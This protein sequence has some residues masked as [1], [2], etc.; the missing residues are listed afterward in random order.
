MF[1][2]FD[3]V[4]II[5]LRERT[6]RRRTMRRELA[7]VGGSA[8]FYDAIRPGSKGPFASAGLYGSFLSHQA[9]IRD[10]AWS[11]ESVLIIEDDCN[12]LPCAK[13]YSVPPCDVFYGSHSEDADEIVGAHC[14]GFS[15]RAVVLLDRYLSDFLH[16]DFEGEGKRIR[17]PVDGAY[18]WF[19]HRAHP[20][21]TTH[22]A[23]LTYQRG[24]RSDCTPAH[25]YDQVPVVRALAEFAR[26]LRQRQS[27][28]DEL[29]KAEVQLGR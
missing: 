22:F 15:A 4:K 21:L 24:S 9:I 23:L 7:K 5:S 19:R 1:E 10:A 12:F 11:G 27:R 6:D 18:V 26:S 13:D 25:A 28:A 8:E 3:G 14:M 29:R 20:E 2:A 16:P 17:P